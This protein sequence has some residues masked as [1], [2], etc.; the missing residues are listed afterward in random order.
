MNQKTNKKKEYTITINLRCEGDEFKGKES[1]IISTSNHEDKFNLSHAK[2]ELKLIRRK[3]YNL[4]HVMFSNLNSVTKSITKSLMLYTLI[5]SQSIYISKLY[6]DNGKTKREFEEDHFNKFFNGH[7]NLYY[8]L[9]HINKNNIYQIFNGNDK[10]QKEKIIALTFLLTSIDSKNVKDR[11][12]KAW[13]SY[14]TLYKIKS[15]SDKDFDGLRFISND[16]S[17]NAD[18]YP[19]LLSFYDDDDKDQKFIAENINYN[20]FIQNNYSKKSQFK[21]Y[22]DFINN[23]KDYRLLKIIKNS[24]SVLKNHYKEEKNG[25]VENEWLTLVNDTGFI[26]NKELVDNINAKINLNTKDNSCLAKTI[27]NK[28]CYFVRNKLFHG[29]LKDSD[30]KIL[31]NTEKQEYANDFLNE[32]LIRLCIDL[33]NRENKQ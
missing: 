6:I 12:E 30:F 2:I 16:I 27:C 29:E 11:F 21:S 23:R 33:L 26:N 31:K 9:K 5:T 1:G 4:E 13:R 24:L 3:K 8:L 32:S 15:G 19:L 20:K 14:N 7:N 25:I 17:Q 10:F 22:K 18:L 28:Y